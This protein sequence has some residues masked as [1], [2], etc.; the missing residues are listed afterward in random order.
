VIVAPFDVAPAGRMAVCAD[1]VGASFCVWEARA[2]EGAQC[3]NEPSGWAI[4]AL[5]TS[6][7]ARSAAFYGEAFG[8][9]TEAFGDFSR[10][11]LPGYF[12]GAAA[13]GGA[14]HGRRH[15]GVI[16]RAR[17]GPA[18]S[19]AVVQARGLGGSRRRGVHRQSAARVKRSR[20]LALAG[21]VTAAPCAARAQA[22]PVVRLV[23]VTGN[24]FAIA[25]F[26]SEM[27]FFKEAGLDVALSQ[28]PGGGAA[29]AALIGGSYDVAITNVGSLSAAFI[30]GLPLT[31][32]GAGGALYSSSGPSAFLVAPA[33]TTI[34][35]AKDLAG[36]TIGLSSVRD[37]AQ[38][39][40]MSWIDQNGGD[41]HAS[42]FVEIPSP[43]I[44]P[45]VERGR[46]DAGL[47]I[48]PRY[49]Q[50]KENFHLIA[51]PYDAIAKQF[52]I[53]GPVVNR[54]WLEQNGATAK[55]LGAA[56]RATARWANQNTEQS[57]GLVAKYTKIPLEIVL[58]TARA[59]LAV[60]IEPRMLQPLIDALAK[61]AFVPRRFSASEIIAK[62]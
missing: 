19:G 5:L 57:S 55:R 31:L 7:L 54:T 14:R 49:V 50:A 6:D 15:D 24:D 46:I 61:Y 17:P 12:G 59:P 60:D 62:V 42:T 47:V 41:S 43:D 11:R 3:V 56:L 21:A 29:T 1:R 20:I 33:T 36:R 13:A 38:C 4:N 45:G 58:K 8:W 22:A 34:R 35:S 52:L 48:N 53:S 9:Q 37:L 27:G 23:A 2:R 10:W 44:A 30:R 51:T 39:A 18:D 32:L 28:I 25:Y 16:R 40:V 26:A